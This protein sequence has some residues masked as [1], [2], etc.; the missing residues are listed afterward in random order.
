M[1]N[2][3]ARQGTPVT[4]GEEYGFECSGEETDW[5]DVD[6]KVRDAVGYAGNL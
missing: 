4:S 6:A 2:T 5:H 1:A 3:T